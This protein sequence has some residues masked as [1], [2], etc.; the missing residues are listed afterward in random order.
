MPKKT[1]KGGGKTE[2]ERLVQQQQRAQAEE[3]MAKKKEET[4]TLFLKD[5]LQK[6]ER[7]TAVNQLKLNESWRTILRQ[8]RA[9]ELHE[10]AAVLQQTLERQLDELNV[11]IQRV[12]NDLQEAARQAAHA[13]RSHLQQVEQLLAQQDRR[14]QRLQEQW[15]DCM[16]DLKATLSAER[17]QMLSQCEQQRLK[18][19]DLKL[20]ADQQHSDWMKEIHTLYKGSLS[21]YVGADHEKTAAPDEHQKLKEVYLHYSEAL[22][23]R[24]LEFSKLDQMLTNNQHDIE[25]NEEIQK[26]LE[27]DVLL[28]REQVK[29][30][31]AEGSLMES[32]LAA[33]K[34]EV[35]HKLSNLRNTLIRARTAARKQLTEFSIHDGNTAGKLQAAFSK[36]EKLLLVAEMCCKQE[37]ISL[38]SPSSRPTEEQR[39]TAAEEVGEF[40][41]LQQLMQ[42]LNAAVLQREILRKHGDDLRRENEQLEA[43]LFQ[44]DDAIDGRHALLAVSQAP[45]TTVP[46]TTGRRHTVIEAVHVVRHSL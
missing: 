35:N 29:L 14:L 37:S 34:N 39:N 10:D 19:Q 17:K 42:R 43:L 38:S 36:A 12:E 25:S 31:K 4:L 7:N 1:K 6:E 11:V 16:Q 41:D 28:L 21:R 20:S 2:E 26:K 8:T 45:T 5:K 30:G 18:L 13:Q 27:E 9:V 40:L 3:E 32:D 22:Q 15:E 44:Q 24:A 23:G 46:S 33:A